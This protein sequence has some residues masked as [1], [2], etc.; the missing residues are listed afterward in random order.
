MSVR[1]PVILP[2]PRRPEPAP[3]EVPRPVPLPT[4]VT[5]PSLEETL[6]KALREAARTCFEE[7]VGRIDAGTVKSPTEAVAFFRDCIHRNLRRWDVRIQ[8]V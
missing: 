8:P 1:P 2:E 6:K 3:R 7:L 4:P 5:P